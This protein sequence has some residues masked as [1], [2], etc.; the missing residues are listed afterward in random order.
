MYIHWPFHTTDIS[1]NKIRRLYNQTLQGHDGFKNLKMAISRP[2][3]LRDILCKTD[4]PIIQNKNVSD[5]LK[6]IKSDDTHQKWNCRNHQKWNCR[7]HLTTLC[8]PRLHPPHSHQMKYET[9]NLLNQQKYNT[10][11]KTQLVIWRQLMCLQPNILFD[12]STNSCTIIHT[13]MV[14]SPLLN[15][16][17][18]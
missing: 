2:K 17:S 6:Q 4:L 10:K 14:Y 11:S 5:I 18:K 12:Q 1:K 9:H 7:K 8:R 16:F 13:S 15:S 3:N